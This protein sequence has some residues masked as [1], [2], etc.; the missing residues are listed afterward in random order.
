MQGQC[1]RLPHTLSV[2]A[3]SSSC[4][5]GTSNRV[6]DSYIGD[7]PALPASHADLPVEDAIN[8][9]L[10][11]VGFDIMRSPAVKA[12]LIARVH[13]KLNELRI[14]DYMHG[15]EVRRSSRA[16]GLGFRFRV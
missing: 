13:K 3:A 5:T 10:A 12:L 8:M 15:I 16:Q 2:M 1:S 11:R 7:P 4:C 14:P 9:L 6:P